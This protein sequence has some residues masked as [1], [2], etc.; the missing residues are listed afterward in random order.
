M[1]VGVSLREVKRA[2][3]RH[4]A[5]AWFDGQQVFVCP[6]EHSADGRSEHCVR[7]ADHYGEYRQGLVRQVESKAF[8]RGSLR[9][10]FVGRE[11]RWGC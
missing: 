7:M 6:D 10:S 8:L 5:L 4:V 1:R 2:Q 11:P 9:C 3:H